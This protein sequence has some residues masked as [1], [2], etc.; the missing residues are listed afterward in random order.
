MKTYF[1]LFGA[2]AIFTSLVFTSCNKTDDVVADEIIDELNIDEATVISQ[3]I[4]AETFDEVSEINDEAIQHVDEILASS[5]LKEGQ[6]GNGNHRGHGKHGR[7]TRDTLTL[8]GRELLRL[9]ECVTITRE[10]NETNDT[11]TM[12]ID[13]GTEN[14]MGPDGRERRGKIIINRYGTHYWDG[15]VEVINTFEDYFVNDNEVIGTKTMNGYINGEGNR[16]QEMNDSGSIILAE[17]AGTITWTATR[18]REVVEGS[19]TRPKFDDVI[20]V[21]GNASGSDAEGNSYTSEI[22]QALVRIHERGCHRHPVSGIVEIF[23]SPDTNITI[24]YGDGTCDNLA[25]V[26]TNG[27][28]EEVEL[29]KRKKNRP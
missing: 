26:T 9:S 5:Q 28:T 13:F 10:V 23:R 12:V 29:G 4:A 17:G 16:V 27:V 20:H 24:N 14:C 7:H 8:D 1:K 3:T 6:G 2:F 21:T 11:M 19:D 18:T 25:E 22:T 15:G